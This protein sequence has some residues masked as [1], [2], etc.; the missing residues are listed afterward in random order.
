MKT[1]RNIAIVAAAGM[2]TRF[3][4][5]LPKQFLPLGDKP[6]V[7]H[8]LEL[9]ERSELMDEVILVVPEDYLA[10][11]SQVVVDQFNFTKI[12]KIKA[13]G[14]TRQESVMA[15]LSACP[16]GI[17]LV[18]IHDGDR[19][20]LTDTLLKEVMTRAAIDGAAILAVPARE[21]I[22]MAENGFIS[23]T[24]KRDVVW[25]AQ[26]PQVFRFVDIL[27]AHRRAEA[28]HHDAT[29]DSELFE[30]Y[31]GRVAIIHGCYNNIKITTPGD[32]I[33]ARAMYKELK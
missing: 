21:S 16:T 29:D 5:E 24:M 31:C 22:K 18:V 33:L 2:G 23:K 32:L 8:C 3:G 1:I 11:A 4:S 15:G 10:Y 13:G 19:P 6:M 20:F 7:V 25:I 14:K 12:R 17:D 27:D 30:Q 26:T 28:A 9:F